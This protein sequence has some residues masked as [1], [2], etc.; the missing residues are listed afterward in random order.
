M[1]VSNLTCFI[2]FGRICIGDDFMKKRNKIIIGAVATALAVS[3]IVTA[4]YVISVKKSSAIIPNGFTVTA[5]TG[6]EGTADNSLEAIKTGIKAG[7]DIV[8]FDLTFNENG[9]AF[10]A[11]DEIT[12]DSVTLKDAFNA[13]AEYDGI[14]INVDCK[15]TKNLKAVTETAKKCGISERIFY[16]GITADDVETVKNNTPEVPYYL[17]TDIDKSQKND[18][19][20][21][22]SLIE[23]TK[24]CGAVGININYGGASKKMVEFFHN[25]DLEISVWTVN[26]E[27]DM[28]KVLT[29]GCD[30]ITTRA[31]RKLIEI[32]KEK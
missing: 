9:E 30:N 31:P 22:K 28:H 20:Y 24:E 14:K 7:A 10:L 4:G 32:I 19:E 16:T 26:K 1:S 23:K 12:P 3:S 21:I 27:L 29:L 8:E 11:H 15:S 2:L 5:H 6:C 17:N 13:V 25:E 18:D